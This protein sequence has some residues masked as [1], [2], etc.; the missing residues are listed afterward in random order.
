MT[1]V[2]PE[3]AI[4]SRAGVA[5]I[6]AEFLR[7]RAVLATGRNFS[8]P[9]GTISCDVPLHRCLISAEIEMMV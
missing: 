8:I 7:E 5:E 6:R 9:L 1:K 3:A 4:G 2:R